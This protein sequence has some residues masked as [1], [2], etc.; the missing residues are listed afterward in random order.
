M[1][2]PE[3]DTSHLGVGEWECP[4]CDETKRVIQMRDRIDVS[5][6]ASLINH[7]RG[8]LDEGHGGYS[9]FPPGF[10]NEDADQYI[11]R[12]TFAADGEPEVK[13]DAASGKGLVT[14]D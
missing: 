5:L 14:S 9:R 4:F 7:L 3:I 13:S 1:G 2:S 11:T 12:G 10:K 8:T 6:R